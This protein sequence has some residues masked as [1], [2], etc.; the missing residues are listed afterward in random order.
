MDKDILG[1]TFDQILFHCK[2][3]LVNEEKY[4]PRSYKSNFVMI[5]RFT[6]SDDG[7]TTV[8]ENYFDPKFKSLY[9]IEGD[10]AIN[11]I[12]N[13]KI[14][15]GTT[16]IYVDLFKSNLVT[17]DELSKIIE[18][19]RDER[20]KYYEHKMECIIRNY[21]G[22]SKKMLDVVIKFAYNKS[23]LLISEIAIEISS[24]NAWSWMRNFALTC[25]QNTPLKH[26]LNQ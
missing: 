20:L 8:Y 1:Y 24:D 25:R 14:M 4:E 9:T 16:P 22:K 3:T 10:Y 17:K 15:A 13:C 7:Y 12:C 21:D 18:K 23:S 19:M 6:E 11:I 2:I 5:N 26:L